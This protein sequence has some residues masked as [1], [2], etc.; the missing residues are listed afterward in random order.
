VQE[1]TTFL[2]IRCFTLRQNTERP[3]TL[4]LGTNTLLGLNP[5]R[6]SDIPQSLAEE[7]VSAYATPPLWDG[8][9]AQRIADVV[10]PAL[11]GSG[12]TKPR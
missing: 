2:G 11:V 8:H 3:I 5:Q 6:I 12:V 1:E 4:R 7:S 10:E 9:E